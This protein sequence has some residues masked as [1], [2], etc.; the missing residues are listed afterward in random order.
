MKADNNTVEG[1][2]D[3]AFAAGRRKL[4]DGR[5][6]QKPE[7]LNA[8]CFRSCKNMGSAGM[9]SRTE[10]RSRLWFKTLYPVG[11]RGVRIHSM[12]TRAE[13]QEKRLSSATERGPLSFDA[14]V[15]MRDSGSRFYGVGEIFRLVSRNPCPRTDVSWRQRVRG[16][17]ARLRFVIETARYNN[18]VFSRW[19]VRRAA[20]EDASAE[21]SRLRAIIHVTYH[22]NGIAGCMINTTK[23]QVYSEIGIAY[24]RDTCIGIENEVGIKNDTGSNLTPRRGSRSRH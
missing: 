13:P 10:S 14:R 24:G 15:H 9:V 1:I 17:G 2:K 11:I 23:D 5:P 16:D 4:A 12:L 18:A 6:C 8:A 21:V 20:P 19:P 3:T 22:R 7:V